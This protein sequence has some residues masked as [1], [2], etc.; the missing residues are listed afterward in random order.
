MAVP[1][2]DSIEATTLQL[3]RPR[4][5]DNVFKANNTLA[6]FLMRGRVK[7]ASGGRYISEPIIYGVNSTTKMYRG[8][9]RLTIAPTEEITDAQFSWRL[10][11][12][13][14]LMSGE[15][16]LLNSG[17]EA[18]FNLL[19]AKIKVAELSLRQFFD[20][21]IHGPTSGKDLNVDFLGLD[22]MFDDTTSWSTLGGIN[23]NTYSFW[24]NQLG[25]KGDGT[26]GWG[27]AGGSET[28][29]IA[30]PGTTPI[31]IVNS[32]KTLLTALLN[33]M[34]HLCSK[35]SPDMPDLILTS[36]YW[37]EKY[38]NDA[39][40]KLRLYDTD[41]AQLGFENIKFK[42]ARIMWNENMSLIS[43]GLSG[44][45]TA[46]IYFINSDYL[47]FTIHS[48]RNFKMSAFMSPYDQD[49]KVAQMLWA[50]NMTVNNRRRL[51]VT[52]V[53]AA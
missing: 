16:G 41:L 2:T 22:E 10:G 36:Q 7:T 39:L 20:E 33:R 26:T 13:S 5:V 45:E 46:P 50:G 31:T 29:T 37:Y 51:G 21:K 3:V 23:G 11:A 1:Q 8:Y 52:W 34:Y 14:I 38:E 18:K 6:W 27:L 9:D 19:N 43:A 40:D 28:G 15:E 32:D 17:P 24:R 35:G 25:P 44:T 42:G 30:T 48:Q 53:D 47:S 12:I 49:A 4:L